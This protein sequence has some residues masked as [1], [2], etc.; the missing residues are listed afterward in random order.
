MSLSNLQLLGLSPLS[1][2]HT[3]L[4]L[5]WFFGW[6]SINSVWMWHLL[7]RCETNVI[8]IHNKNRCFTRLWKKNSFFSVNK[9]DER[10]YSIYS[11]HLKDFLSE[12]GFFHSPLEKKSLVL[13]LN[14]NKEEF[15]C[16][17]DD[18]GWTNLSISSIF[19]L[20]FFFSRRNEN[21]LG[22][23]YHVSCY[24]EEC[25]SVSHF[26]VILECSVTLS[27]LVSAEFQLQNSFHEIL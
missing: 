20:L 3:I 7:K 16:K 12:I 13:S 2:I 8:L 25:S 19:L 24:S 6:N 17:Y 10:F 15:F 23:V 11:S 4:K 21:S 22:N 18:K 9:F 5:L 1:S 14:E 27:A 26:V